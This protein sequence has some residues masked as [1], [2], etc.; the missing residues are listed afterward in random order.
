MSRH[1]GSVLIVSL[2]IL[3]VLTI[4]GVNSMQYSGL[5]L[6]VVSSAN[7]RSVA[8]EG[9]ETALKKIEAKLSSHPPTLISHYSDCSGAGC[10]NSECKGGLCFAGEYYSSQERAQCYISDPKTQLQHDFWSDKKLNVWGYVD[11]HLTV[12]VA[13]LKRP[14]KYIIE[15]LCFTNIGA[16]LGA[17]FSTQGASA[18]N[19]EN[20]NHKPLYR[21]TAMASG[22]ARRA[23]VVLQSTYRVANES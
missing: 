8:F 12:N 7:D 11:R 6:K 13:G 23:T 20:E 16:K 15:F 18:S 2:I 1:S 4:I 17:G 9:V 14:V 3:G 10:F 5:D 21:I 22:N 19:S